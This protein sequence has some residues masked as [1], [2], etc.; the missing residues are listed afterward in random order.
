MPRRPWRRQRVPARARQPSIDV[1]DHRPV[2]IGGILLDHP[3]QPDDAVGDLGNDAVGTRPRS[4]APQRDCTCERTRAWT[5][6]KLWPLAHFRVT[7]D[8]QRS[9][10]PVKHLLNGAGDGNRTRVAS[11]EDW[12]STIELRPHMPPDHRWPGQSSRRYRALRRPVGLLPRP[13]RAPHGLRRCRTRGEAGTAVAARAT[14]VLP[15]RQR[16]SVC[17]RRCGTCPAGLTTS[18]STPYTRPN[19]VW[20]SLVAHSLWERGAVGSNPATPTRSAT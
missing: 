6:P 14:A 10:R 3:G 11:L 16:A 8:P 4:T 5:R 20:R 19:G 7:R 15:V 18:A 2:R 9:A 17:E 1:A 13:R 12:D